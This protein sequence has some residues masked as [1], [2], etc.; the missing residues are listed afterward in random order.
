MSVQHTANRVTSCQMNYLCLSASSG[1]SKA[2]LLYDQ[3][4]SLKRFKSPVQ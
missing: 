2:K 4:R 1:E 3:C